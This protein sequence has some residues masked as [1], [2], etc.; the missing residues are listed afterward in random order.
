MA[1][2]TYFPYNSIAMSKNGSD[3]VANSRLLL[4]RSVNSI[5]KIID[6]RLNSFMTETLKNIIKGITSN[7]L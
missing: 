4:K 7:G 6:L 1:N 2:F 3:R 5:P